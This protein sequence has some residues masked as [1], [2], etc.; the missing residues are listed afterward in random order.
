MYYIKYFSNYIHIPGSDEFCA[1]DPVLDREAN[2][3]GKLTFFIL[4]T[5]PYFGKLEKLKL[6][7]TVE[8]DGKVLFRGR[9]VNS[10]QEFDN[11]YAV[12]VEGKFAVLNDS[13]CRPREFTGTPEELFDWFLE[14]HNSQ[15]SESQ[16]F[17]KGKVTVTDPNNY[18]V[19]SW[20]NTEKTL[21]L[22]K[23]RLID[24]LGGYLVVRYEEDG[25]Y[26][27]WIEKFTSYSTQNVEFG[28]NL[29]D[30]EMFIDA[31]ETYT[32][33]V[34]YGAEIMN[35]NYAEVDASAA[36]WQI[37]KY[38]LVS[39]DE[40]YSLIQDEETF[41]A[42][43]SSGT[44]VY[45]ILSTGGT[46]KRL[47]IESVNDGKD[48]IVNEAAAEKYGVIYAPIELVT[49][50]DVTRPENLFS[51]AEEWLNN[52]GVTFG[53]TINLTFLD[54][55]K[56]GLETGHIEM[57]QNVLIKSEPH[58]LNISYLVSKIQLPLDAPE[59]LKV[60][61]GITERTF[62]DMTLGKKTFEPSGSPGADGKSAYEI[63]LEAGNTGSKKDY[64]DS[65]KGETGPQGEQ[66]LPGEKGETGPQGPQGPKGEKGDQGIQGLQGLQGPKGDQGAQG[67]QG[68]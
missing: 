7:V 35:V 54:L 28:E 44:A 21:T 63:W 61:L 42:A 62:T 51:K 18:I 11:E 56:L 65:L 6:G 52:E 67:P 50:D 26:L 55:S 13:L 14:N 10:E 36:S 59:E 20:D 1:I 64:L 37:D 53:S 15:V 30:L 38:Y 4:D 49:W 9:V 24:T 34:P 33:C 57:F 27:D 32:A 8:E 23:S 39:D 60:T 16:R 58:N 68:E 31:S 40:T 12:T 2:R 25:D 19:R 66:G 29:L 5:H 17:K 45:E 48:Y 43:V 22:M 3:A 46:G 41:D 47:T